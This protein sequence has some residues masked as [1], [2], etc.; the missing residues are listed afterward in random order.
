MVKKLVK[1]VVEEECK[2]DD[3]V[4]PF[5]ESCDHSSCNKGWC[6]KGY[7]DDQEVDDITF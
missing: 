6:G 7:A 2:T 5:G 3:K 4:V 1:P